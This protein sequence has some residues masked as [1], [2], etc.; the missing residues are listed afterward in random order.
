M[1]FRALSVV[2]APVMLAALAATPAVASTG[3]HAARINVSRNVVVST[4]AS[5]IQ[6]TVYARCDGGGLGRI[7]V[8]ATQQLASAPYTV[9]SRY[10]YDSFLG[11]GA[12]ACDNVEHTLVISV[13]KVSGTDLAKGQTVN[14]WVTVRPQHEATVSLIRQATVRSH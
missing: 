3:P 12:I 14:L 13:P 6:A 9:T 7:G 1:K 2:A 8:S 5:H 4:D 10:N 11:A